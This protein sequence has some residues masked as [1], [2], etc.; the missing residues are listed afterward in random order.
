MKAL[1][2]KIFNKTNIETD[3]QAMKK[4]SA[5]EG[6]EQKMTINNLSF[7]IDEP[8]RQF[9]FSSI[10]EFSEKII[11]KVKEIAHKWF[12]TVVEDQKENKKEN[13]QEK[14]NQNETKKER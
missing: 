11:N 3:L 10:K 14:K 12:F 8:K 5:Y 6:K 2:G 4:I 1:Y 7:G 13:T 9:R